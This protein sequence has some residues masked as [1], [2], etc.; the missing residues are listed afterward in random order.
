MRR[1]APDST[2]SQARNISAALDGGNGPTFGYQTSAPDRDAVFAGAG[3]TA[4]FGR[5][6]NA[7]FFYNIDF[8]RQD[9]LGNYISGGLTW[10]F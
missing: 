5:N 3:V 1:D 8:G 9:Y 7:F 10:K 4:Q 2:P 6:W